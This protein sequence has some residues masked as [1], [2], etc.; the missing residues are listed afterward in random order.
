MRQLLLMGSQKVMSQLSVQLFLV[1]TK[2]PSNRRKVQINNLLRLKNIRGKS[3]P[4]R[5]KDGEDWGRVRWIT[6]ES[7][8]PENKA[9]A[10][11]FLYLTITFISSSNSYRGAWSSRIN[12]HFQWLEVC[13]K[14]PKKIVAIASQGREDMN[15]WVTKYR[16]TFSMDKT[17]YVYYKQLGVTKVCW[18]FQRRLPTK[19]PRH[20]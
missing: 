18:D 20:V 16:L 3:K 7:L 17:H 2:F 9:N 5:S 14:R 13:F 6:K 4:K 10:V 12:D 8:E 1:G 19:T 15:Q 11:I